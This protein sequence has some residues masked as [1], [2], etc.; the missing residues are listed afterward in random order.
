MADSV[1]W[2][3]LHDENR[4]PQRF[5]VSVAVA[6]RGTAPGAKLLR[7]LSAA[8]G[9]DGWATACHIIGKPAVVADIFP[10]R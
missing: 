10:S 5:W 9:L 6:L 8:P 4:G 7:P 2:V 1:A 3:S